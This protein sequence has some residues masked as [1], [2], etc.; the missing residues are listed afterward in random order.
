MRR[1]IHEIPA[2]LIDLAFDDLKSGHVA[3]APVI[4]DS[5]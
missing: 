5:T 2:K 3:G 1:A 4:P